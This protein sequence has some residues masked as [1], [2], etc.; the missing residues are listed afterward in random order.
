MVSPIIISVIVFVHI[1]FLIALIRKNYSVI[2]IGWGLGC[3]LAVFVAWQLGASG[4]K[5]NLLLGVVA[6]WGVRLAV[7]ILTRSWGKGED[8]RYTKF[9]NEWKPNENLQ[10]YLK[11]FLFQGLLMM[12][13]TLPA[14]SAIA[15][16]IEELTWINWIGLAVWISGFS[17]E[18]WSDYFLNWWKAQ[19]LNKGKICTEGPWKLCRFPNYFGEVF[20]WYGVYLLGFSWET[21]WSIIGA[22]AINFLILKVT[23]VPLLED[24][25]M[26]REEYRKYAEKVPRF[27][28]LTRP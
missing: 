15:S 21:S 25:Y 8:P 12:I 4:L 17:L 13:V 14:T 28:P 16:G 19:P 1:F 20:L 27:I 6:V 26:K 9:R 24:K 10:A 23:G 11:V 2:D 3:F 22:I 18:V 7:Y 5:S